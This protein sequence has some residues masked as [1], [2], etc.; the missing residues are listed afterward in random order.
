MGAHARLD[1]G[2]P[3]IFKQSQGRYTSNAFTLSLSKRHEATVYIGIIEGALAS[4]F[5]SYTAE[6]L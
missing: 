1:G 5:K 3:S 6:V 2:S 4:V